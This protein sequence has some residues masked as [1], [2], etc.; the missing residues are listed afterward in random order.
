[1]Q[2]GEERRAAG[3]PRTGF[4]NWAVDEIDRLHEAAGRAEAA[5]HRLDLQNRAG[6]LLGAAFAYGDWLRTVAELEVEPARGVPSNAGGLSRILLATDGSEGAQQAERFLALLQLSPDACVRLLVVADASGWTMPEWF[7]QIQRSWGERTVEEAAARLQ[8]AGIF[9]AQELRSGDAARET[10]EAARE[11]AAELILVGGDG[12]SGHAGFPIGR[13]AR[14]V[15]RLATCP[16]LVARSTPARLRRVVIAV[17]ESEYSRR[18]VELLARFPLPGDVQFHVLSVVRPYDPFAGI[19]P[20]D[21]V[22]FREE[23]KAERERRRRTAERLVARAA[24]TLESRGRGATTEVR[25]GDPAA[26]IL[27]AAAERKAGLVAAGARGV[28]LIEG[29]RMGSV[30]DRLLHAAPCPLLI[31]R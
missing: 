23:V 31:V 22:G 25:V 12:E 13:V 27:S 30:A 9:P 28:S 16:V 3:R 26:E 20:D 1:M 18:C 2:E 21:P 24:S 4:L 10:V 8:E 19:A 14:N 6:M 5:D 7:K 29:L 15:A 17:D 11:A